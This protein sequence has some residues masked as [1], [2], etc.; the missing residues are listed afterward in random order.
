MTITQEK[1]RT[2]VYAFIGLTLAVIAFLL[3]FPDIKGSLHISFLLIAIVLTGILFYTSSS[4]GL[5]YQVASKSQQDLDKKTYVWHS[6]FRVRGNWTRL[7]HCSNN[8]MTVKK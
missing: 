2:L 5:S 1:S 4:F 3:V 6:V 7:T 8:A